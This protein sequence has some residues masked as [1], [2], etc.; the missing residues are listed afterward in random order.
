MAT[1]AFNRFNCLSEDLALGK[2]VFGT[3]V[4]KVAL[5]DTAPVVTNS[6]LANLTHLTTGGGYTAPS[7]TSGGVTLD[8]VVA[9]RTGAQTKITIA[10]ET[11]TAAG[12]SIG[13]FRYAVIYNSSETGQPLVGW[14]DYGSSIT[15]SDGEPFLMD[16]DGTNGVFTIG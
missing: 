14:Y 11:I 13:P 16:F 12:A 9:A 3:D 10:D 7:G 2:H 1:A 15:L 8:S 5:V 6:L 4:Y